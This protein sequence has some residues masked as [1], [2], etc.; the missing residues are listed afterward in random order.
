MSNINNFTGSNTITTL[1]SSTLGINCSSSLRATGDLLEVSVSP[2]GSYLYFNSSGRLGAYNTTNS[3]FPWYIDITGGLGSFITVNSTNATLTNLY[4]SSLS[5]NAGSSLRSALDIMEVGISPTGSYLYFNNSGTIGVYNTTLLNSP[6][7]IT[8]S[9]TASIPT[10]NSTNVNTTNATITNSTITNST[11]TNSTITTST[12]SKTIMSALYNTFA[13]YN[14]TINSPSFILL[15][16][17]YNM[18][19]QMNV[20]SDSSAFN[21]IYEFRCTN[22]STVTFQSMASNCIMLDLSNNTQTTLYYNTKNYFKFFYTYNSY[23]NQYIYYLLTV[24]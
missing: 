23:S 19:V 14:M 8:V 10:V 6:W 7:Y 20:L 21:C 1:Y 16:S 17:T 3:T 18:T 22:S 13:I 24:G 4:S 15:A 5:V 2:T 9:G 12:V 11:I